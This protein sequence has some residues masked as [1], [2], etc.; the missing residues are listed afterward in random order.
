MCRNSSGDVSAAW[1]N[2]LSAR[3]SAVW[4]SMVSAWHSAASLI[5]QQPDG[6][7]LRS[8]DSKQNARSIPL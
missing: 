2:T 8:S 7:V 3:T 1:V 6:K 4:S 5:M